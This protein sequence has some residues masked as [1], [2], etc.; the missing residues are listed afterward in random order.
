MAMWKGRLQD[1][2][3]DKERHP[4][5]FM[6]DALKQVLSYPLNSAQI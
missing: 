4:R 3:A 1:G 5:H 6:E 2:F